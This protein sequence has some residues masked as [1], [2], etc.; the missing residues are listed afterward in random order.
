MT[1]HTR[2][3]PSTVCPP[4][5]TPPCVCYYVAGITP[6][7]SRANDRP[8]KLIKKNV[9]KTHHYLLKNT[10][11][12]DANVV[13][14]IMHSLIYHQTELLSA[15]IHLQLSLSF[16][17]CPLCFSCTV[18]FSQFYFC[19]YSL[20]NWAYVCLSVPFV[21]SFTEVGIGP[22]QSRHTVQT[23]FFMVV[24][25]HNLFKTL[26]HDPMFCKPNGS[27]QFEF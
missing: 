25:V 8:L 26:S 15:V 22:S 9:P 4:E 27:F 23:M 11:L 21:W 19:F 20:L 16:L 24:V 10:C 17:L 7:Q 1:Q 5:T 12:L 18:C 13:F 14:S 3:E 6:V 2:C